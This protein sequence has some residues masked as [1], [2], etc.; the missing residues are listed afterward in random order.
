MLTHEEVI[1]N[2]LSRYNAVTQ[3]YKTYG[4]SEED[5][6]L[7]ASKTLSAK[8]DL[9]RLILANA[10][11]KVKQLQAEIDALSGEFTIDKFDTLKDLTK[12]INDLI[13]ADRTKLDRTNYDKLLNSYNEYLENLRTDVLPVIKEVASTTAGSTVAPIVATASALTLAGAVFAIIK[14]RWLF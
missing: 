12:R 4:I 7:Y 13:T 14:K 2:A 8:A 10:S 1:N 11:T 3:D 5:W 6:N 9:R